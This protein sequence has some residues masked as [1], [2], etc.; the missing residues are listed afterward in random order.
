MESPHGVYKYGQ[1]LMLSKKYQYF[2]LWV[3]QPRPKETVCKVTDLST[4]TEVGDGSSELHQLLPN[5]SE[6]DQIRREHCIFLMNFAYLRK[7]ENSIS[8]KIL[9]NSYPSTT[10]HH[11]SLRVTKTAFYF[12]VYKS[13]SLTEECMPWNVLAPL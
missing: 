4:S 10:L 7:A 3:L 1:F 5:D 9:H 2:Q 11:K 6:P 12:V 8:L 13:F